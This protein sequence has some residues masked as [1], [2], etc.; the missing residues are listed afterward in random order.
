MDSATLSLECPLCG[1]TEFKKCFTKKERHFFRCLKCDLQMQSPLPTLQEL[2]D[3][4]ESSFVD[5]M[6]QDFASA[7]LLK[8]MTAQ[9][10]IKEIANTI[11]LEGKWLDVGCANGV[12]VETVSGRGVEAQGIEL[13]EHAVSIGKERGLNL[14]VGTVDDLPVDESFDCITAF[15][16]L[17]HVLEPLDFIGGIHKRLNDGGHV[18]LTVPNT[19]GIVRR[20]MGK[21]WYFYIPEEHLHYFNS[22]NLAGLLEKQG[23][24]VLSVGPTYKPMTYNYALLQFAEFNPLIHKILKAP[25]FLIPSK[26]RERPIPLPIGELRII[27]QKPLKVASGKQGREDLVTETS[28]N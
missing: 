22:T 15:D 7:D 6:Y 4:Y 21:R 16:V 11:P 3:F 13:S 25:S 26:L 20:I 10:R 5:G 23:F 12:F 9:Q 8:R 24:D 14:H 19:G 2:A 28:R 27:A 18:V 17:E 1:V